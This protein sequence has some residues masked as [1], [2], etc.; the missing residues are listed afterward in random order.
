MKMLTFKDLAAIF[1]KTET[2][3]A[4]WVKEGILPPP[5]RFGRRAVLWRAGDLEAFV[6]A[7]PPATAAETEQPEE[8]TSEHV[9]S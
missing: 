7:M 3:I 4:R 8:V 2:T 1:K 5:V 9:P 6:Q